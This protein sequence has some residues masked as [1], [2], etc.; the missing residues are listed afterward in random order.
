[1]GSSQLKADTCGQGE[2]FTERRQNTTFRGSWSQNVGKTLH[3]GEVGNRTS[4]KHYIS[5]KL[6]TERRQNTTFRGR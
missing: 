6:V 5:G 2:L 4:A 3:F 1:M